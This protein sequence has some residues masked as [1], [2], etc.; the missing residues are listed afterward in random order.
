MRE[1][2]ASAAVRGATDSLSEFADAVTGSR[3]VMNRR[4]D[5]LHSWSVSNSQFFASFHSQVR[6]GVIA[7]RE[8]GWDEQRTSAE[9]TIN[10]IYF[11]KLQVAALC[12]DDLGMSYYGPYCVV[13]RDQLIANRA[14]VFEENPFLFCKKHAVYSGATPP[15]GFRATWANRASLAKA[16]CGNNVLPN[17]DPSEFPAIL[18]SSD[19]DSD[20]CDF[21]EVHSRS[22]VSEA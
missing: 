4:L 7:A 5:D 10:P 6:D 16:K 22:R 17:T 18:M 13:L 15:L 3:A 14:S 12:L 19:R 20:K 11:E 21:I 2:D 8:N 9:N 1:V